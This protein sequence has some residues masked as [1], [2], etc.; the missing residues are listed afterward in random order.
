MDTEAGKGL[1]GSVSNTWD[2]RFAYRLEELTDVPPEFRNSFLA[3][4]RS[5]GRPSWALFLP[6]MQIFSLRVPGQIPPRVVL[7][8]SDSLA[9]LSLDPE[10]DRVLSFTVD[11]AGFL[12]YGLGEFLL[13]CWITVYGGI[14]GEGTARIRFPSY[15]MDKYEQLA[16][17]LFGWCQ[18]KPAPEPPTEPTV[19]NRKTLLRELPPQFS[20]F[21]RHHAEF[22]KVSHHFL[23]TPAGPP[24][25]TKSQWPTLLLALTPTGILALSDEYAGRPC[26]WGL[27]ATVLPLR[28]LARAEWV[29]EA[30]SR[31]PAVRVHFRG[32]HQPASFTWRV[33]GGLRPDGVSWVQAV[34]SFLGKCGTLPTEAEIQG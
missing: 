6:A 8:F 7:M 27:E 19:T 22:G 9:L 10:Q 32:A 31:P 15:C 21:L 18:V 23:Q 16:K 26:E 12:G 34:N 17:L 24:S 2:Y 33:F 30:G 1:R 28:S 20:G 4:C 14:Q 11:R 29:E 25:R 5:R 3:T 13:Q